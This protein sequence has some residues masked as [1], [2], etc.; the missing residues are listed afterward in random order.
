MSVQVS[1]HR[2][3]QNEWI[4]EGIAGRHGGTPSTK[5][6]HSRKVMKIA[7]EVKEWFGTGGVAPIAPWW[8]S[9]DSLWRWPDAMQIVDLSYH[10]YNTI[11]TDCQKLTRRF[12]GSFRISYA[13]FTCIHQT[14]RN[15]SL[16]LPAR[17]IDSPFGIPVQKKLSLLLVLPRICQD[18]F[19]GPSSC[20]PSGLHG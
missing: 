13:L 17:K 7:V 11:L 16:R 6:A 12:C 9:V 8:W 20:R 3:E 19:P 4:C 5:T 2:I 1:K 15:L 10:P 14:N 18:V